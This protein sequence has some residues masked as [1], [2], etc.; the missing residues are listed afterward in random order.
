MRRTDGDLDDPP[1]NPNGLQ[2]R[3]VGK[4]E[5]NLWTR[6]FVIS[7]EDVSLANPAMCVLAARICRD[8]MYENMP[9]VKD[10]EHL[11]MNFTI[12][13]T[14]S[15]KSRAVDWACICRIP[16][17]DDTPRPFDMN[18][19][20]TKLCENL[21]AGNHLMSIS[22]AEAFISE[23]LRDSDKKSGKDSASRGL[24]KATFEVLAKGVQHREVQIKHYTNKRHLVWCAFLKVMQLLATNGK[25]YPVVLEIVESCYDL[26]HSERFRWEKTSRLFQRMAIMSICLRDRVEAQGLGIRNGPVDELMYKRD[27][28]V[29]E[30][31]GLRMGLRNG[32]LWYG[33]SEYCMDKHTGKGSRMK[34]GIQ[35]FIEL[36]SFLRHEDMV[37][38]PLSDYYLNLC[39]ETRYIQEYGLE[40]KFETSGMTIPKYIEWL[41][42]LRERHVFLNQL[43]DLIKKQVVT[44]TW[45]EC[46]ESF[47][48][49]EQLGK[50]GDHG[51]TCAELLQ[52]GKTFS[53]NGY[54]SE[55]Y[56]LRQSL[57]YCENPNLPSQFLDRTQEAEDAG[58]LIIRNIANKLITVDPS[59]FPNEDELRKSLPQSD[60]LFLELIELNWDKKMYMKGKVVNKHA[61]WN[62]CFSNER[63]EP[64]YS[65]KK[66]RV[67]DF[68]TLPRLQSIRA[69]LEFCFGEKAT[70]LIAEGNHY[71]DIDKCYISW[72]G[73]FERRI[74]IGMRFG[75]EMSLEYQWFHQCNSVGPKIDFRLRHGDLYIMSNK[76]VGTDWKK[77]TILTLRHG[78]NTSKA[79]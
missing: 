77:K 38:A 13:L 3:R 62:L 36:K 23:S 6:L 54:E 4:G 39:F 65:E 50:K 59:Q 56:D 74:V 76:A 34:R 43:E 25:A 18:F 24:P 2:R 11:A 20:Y 61:R 53:N 9:S 40:G 46:S 21:I 5:N 41:P 16:L 17:P 64:N 57:S 19:M 10:A 8:N 12:M 60:N 37:Y 14:R 69:N 48:G 1:P 44:L 33:P 55:Y 75:A 58:I 27:F 22:Y 30:L 35:H 15:M 26:A 73:D 79:K 66:G 67:I 71:Y 28:T 72:H 78:A 49:M 32:N 42:K 31:E 51:F 47:N 63:Q 52:I 7:C 70:N 29:N 68:K 45:S